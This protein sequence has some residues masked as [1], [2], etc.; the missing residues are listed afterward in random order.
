MCESHVHTITENFS[1]LSQNFN[2]QI[3]HCHNSFQHE[4]FIKISSNKLSV[5]K[6]VREVAFD[7]DKTIQIL[8]LSQRCV[9]FRV[10][11]TFSR[12]SQTIHFN[13]TKLQWRTFVTCFSKRYLK[14]V[15]TVLCLTRK[16]KSINKLFKKLARINLL[17]CFPFWVW[18]FIILISLLSTIT[19]EI[20]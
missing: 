7:L 2:V 19:Y 12:S 15:C 18:P 8:I 16:H 11:D 14:S 1:N 5:G 10:V 4:K 9:H 6:E 3:C 20:P 17:F 13:L